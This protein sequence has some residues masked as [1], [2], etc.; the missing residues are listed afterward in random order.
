MQDLEY[1]TGESSGG[2]QANA[3]DR[4][5]AAANSCTGKFGVGI[6]ALTNFN[7]IK[8]LLG[9][10]SQDLIAELFRKRVS[11][12]LRP[13]DDLI[14]IA[15]DSLCIVLDELIDE[16]HLH[17]A[18]LKLERIFE[19][20]CD[21]AGQ[22]IQMS[23]CSGL[24]FAGRKTRLSKSPGEL[25][26]LAEDTCLDALFSNSAFQLVTASPDVP[27]DHDWQLNQRIQTAMENH[28]IEFD[29][30]P[31]IYMATGELS[32]GEALIR[33]RD[34]GRVIPP[35]E[36]LAALND[37][38]LWQLTIY[39]YRR[40]LR[41]ILEYELNIPISYNIDPSSLAQPD[42]LDFIKRETK[43][44][45]V[46]PEKIILEITESKELFDLNLSKSLLSEIREMGFRISLDDFGAEHSNLLRVRELPLDEIKIDKS[47]SGKVM[48]CEDSRQI[49]QSVI[50]MAQAMDISIVAE[51]IEDAGA[52]QVLKDL[53]CDIGQ[54]YHLGR[55]MAIEAFAALSAPAKD[56]ETPA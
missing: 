28:D 21:A 14:A 20:D 49:T 17:L 13:N 46:A 11:S 50:H 35:D 34:N 41:E 36:Y 51:G 54:G 24:V 44:W 53:G 29:Y 1:Q 43:L 8:D 56:S 4:F 5:S 2:K 9:E 38:V 27:L 12:L 10:D 42:F 23:V 40:V 39:G 55:P 31:K 33:W 30:Q 26:Q 25:Y 37:D 18:G 16:N 45:G 19:L 15:E 52:L 3:P 7:D 47:L 22:I 6:I 32:G 48:E